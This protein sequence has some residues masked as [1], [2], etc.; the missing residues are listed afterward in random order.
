MEEARNNDP[1][2]PQ[3]RDSLS[4]SF[5]LFFPAAVVKNRTVIVID[6]GWTG[7]SLEVMTYY[8][9]RWTLRKNAPFLFQNLLLVEPNPKETKGYRN[10]VDN[11]LLKIDYRIDMRK[12][13]SLS[14][15]L[16]NSALDGFAYFPA[17]YP[18]KNQPE[19][20]RMNPAYWNLQSEIKGKFEDALKADSTIMKR[21]SETK[22]NPLKHCI[23]MFDF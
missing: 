6:Y 17:F 15:L 2:Y 21:L 9:E 20:L 14:R 3:Y 13:K 19:Y 8:L 11:K 18:Y 16:Y 22:S 1:Q 10:A 23:S 4:R 5:D 7:V 12:Y